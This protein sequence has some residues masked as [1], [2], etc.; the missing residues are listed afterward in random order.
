V[1][2]GRKSL[3]DH[4]DLALAQKQPGVPITATIV[5]YD[6]PGRDCAALASNGE[7]PLSQEG[8]QRYKTE[9]IDAITEVL[10]KPKFQDIRIVTVIEPDGLPN[11]VTNL[12]DPECAQANSSGIQVE[13]VQYAL[14]EL[15]A[16]PNVYIY[17][18]IAHS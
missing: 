11:L 7:L 6:L 14:D 2:A 10:A 8:L 17:M 1:N 15:H 5:I 16:I 3:E 12:S 9:Y 18:D 13:A 4:L